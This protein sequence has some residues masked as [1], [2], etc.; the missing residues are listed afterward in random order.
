MRSS[1]Q[2][3][4]A[5]ILRGVIRQ[6]LTLTA[7]GIAIGV[8]AALALTRAMAGVLYGVSPHDP[9]TLATS[10]LLMVVVSVVAGIVPARRA[11]QVDPV[12]T[13]REE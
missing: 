6:G 7:A 5:D 8:V 12:V 13:L 4:T 3:G 9:W 11:T 2:A 10:G 1:R